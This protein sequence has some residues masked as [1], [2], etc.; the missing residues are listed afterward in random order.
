VVVTIVAFIVSLV[1]IILAHEL[2][3]FATAKIAGVRVDEFGIGF[4]PRLFSVKRG[5]TIYSINAFPIGGFVKVA[6]EEDPSAPGGL[7]SKSIP[8][9]LLFLS[10]GSI[11][12]LLLPFL[13][14]S[15]AFMVPHQ[16]VIGQV[17]VEGVAPNSPAA[18]AGIVPGD[19]FLSVNG[20]PVNNTSDVSRLFYTHLGS[21]FTAVIQ[22]SDS[23]TEEVELTARWKPPEDEGAVGVAIITQDATVVTQRY[24][25]KAIPMGAGRCFETLVLFKNGIIS[26][27]IGEIPVE[28]TGPVGIAQ[29]TGEVAKGGISPILE[30]A[31]F[32]SINLGIINLFP[33]PSLDGGRIIFVLL[34]WVRRGKRVSAKTERLIHSIGFILLIGAILAVT[35]KDILRLVTGESLIP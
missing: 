3:H 27:I 30:L 31:A 23:T 22:H 20:K 7:T 5:D 9:R 21:K 26:M 17:V 13:L 18:E 25:W 29:L 10:A 24:S 4:P 16:E 14:L 28:F 32:V 11:M 1:V 34:E 8:A 12:N 2:G 33:I 19:I 6:G 15:I 35:Y